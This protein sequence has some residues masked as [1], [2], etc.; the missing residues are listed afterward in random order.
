MSKK[1]C[2]M[3]RDLLPLYVDGV[4]S[5]LSKKTVS[6]HLAECMECA[7][8]LEK[9][10]RKFSIE[11]DK[12]ISVIR[13]IKKRMRLAKAAAIMIAVVLAAAGLFAGFMWAVTDCTMD[14]EKYHLAENV[15]V[16]EDS[17]GRLWFCMKQ[18]AAS[19]SAI[20]QPTV[21][22]T[23]GDHMG[24]P[25]QNFD[26]E[27]KSGYGITLKM[28][29]ISKL[30]PWNVDGKELRFEVRSDLDYVFYYDDVTDTEYVLWGQKPSA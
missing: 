10:N 25:G 28:F 21:S 29:R 5:E 22:D 14:Y 16:E 19:L 20:A 11:T 18:N 12:D 24:V 26:K 8:E 15:Y 1:N 23:N 3:I 4:C 13:K 17:D 27:K 2:E 6:E 7:A 9:M 30:V